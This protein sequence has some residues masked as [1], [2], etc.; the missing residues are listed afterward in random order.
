M[1]IKKIGP[2]FLSLLVKTLNKLYSMTNPKKGYW[3]YELMNEV[4]NFFLI[5]PKDFVRFHY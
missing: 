3:P 5:L 1:S 2:T 4:V